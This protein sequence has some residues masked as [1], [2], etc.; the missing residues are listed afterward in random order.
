MLRAGATPVR[1]DAQGDYDPRAIS[2][3]YGAVS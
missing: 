2:A 3:K 1:S